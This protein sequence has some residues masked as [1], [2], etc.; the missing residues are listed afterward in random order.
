[1]WNKLFKSKSKK[2][3][4]SKA[5]VFSFKKCKHS[6]E[7]DDHNVAISKTKENLNN[8][9]SGRNLGILFQIIVGIYV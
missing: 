7:N 5:K 6:E 9:Q 4:S 2:E 8:D 3:S 1:M